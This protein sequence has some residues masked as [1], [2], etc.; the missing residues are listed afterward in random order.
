[1][2]KLKIHTL[3]EFYI[4]YGEITITEQVKRSKKMWMLLQY[5]ITFH[6]REISQNELIELLWPK[7]ESNNP[8][9]ALKTQ[10][11]R[12]RTMLT[13]L[14]L[15][16]DEI[17]I[18]SMGT[19]AFNNKLDYEIDCNEFEKTV[20]ASAACYSEKERLGCYMKAIDAYKGDF[21]HKSAMDQWAI[22]INAYYHTMY[23]KVVRSAL[24]IL[25]NF[26]QYNEVV[27]ICRKAILIEQFDES[28]HSYLMRS[29][30]DKGDRQSAKAHYL[31][32]IDLFYNQ[33]GINPSQRFI[34]LY[35]NIMRSENEFG[36]DVASVRVEL[37]EKDGSRDGAFFC[38]YEAFKYIYQLELRES[39]RSQR[40]VFLCII[41]VTDT[42]HQPLTPK[43]L[44][45]VMMK[46]GAVIGRSLRSSD[47][48]ARYSASQFVMLFPGANDEVCNMVLQRVIKFYKRE[49]PKSQ[50]L[51]LFNYEK[52]EK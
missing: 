51:L 11:Y 6:E 45:R 12:L 29:L 38:E 28:I 41:T 31:Y 24:E 16:G 52:V 8:V 42:E 33:E 1:M 32:V 36:A 40:P 3:G 34:S 44:S 14:G 50:A 15:P 37:E 22:P 49:N 46:L 47:V 25:Y 18:N 43:Q 30:V 35:N 39:H 27:E 21:L 13:E 26:K 5:L 2:E 7:G 4:S 48:Y 20:K 23:L 19:Y 10:L 17:I 9:G